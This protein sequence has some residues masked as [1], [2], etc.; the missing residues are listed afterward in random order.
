MKRPCIFFDRDGVVNES[1]GPGYVERWQDF[2]VM[3]GIGPVLQTV[4]KAGYAAVVI[5]N[6]R[7]VAIGRMTAQTVDDIHNRL[8]EQLHREY[9]VSFLDILYCP[10][11][12]DCQVCRKPQPGMLLE[13]ARR[14]DLD[15]RH[16][17][18]VGDQARDIEAGL[19]AGCRGIRLAPPD[20]VCSVAEHTV[21]DLDQLNRLLK[22]I[23]D[24]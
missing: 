1:P 17:W 15:L 11:D 23:L 5:S 24:I 22:R 21:H 8:Q 12:R 20:T 18:M 14:H 19:A 16:S 13:A 10:H 6:Q 7:G 9:G 4:D 2:H 3:P